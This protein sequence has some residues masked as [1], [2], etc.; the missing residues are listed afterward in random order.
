[1]DK[2]FKMLED[3]YEKYND[4][5]F[6][7]PD[8]LEYVLKCNDKKEQEVIGIIASSFA[9]GRVWAIL[10]IVGD[11]L[12]KMNSTP[13]EY[14][15]NSSLEDIKHEF[16]NLE[17]R[18]TTGTEIVNFL[19]GIKNILKE[20]GSLKEC[21]VSCENKNEKNIF[22]SAL[23]FSKKLRES[24]GI[25]GKDRMSLLPEPE[26]TSPC[27]RLI[28]YFRWMIRKDNVDPG[29]WEE[30]DKSKLLVPLDTHMLSIG[31]L[32]GFTKNKTASVKTAEAITS[33]F[34]MYNPQDP[35][36]YD[37]ALTR[38]GIRGDNFISDF[39]KEW[40]EN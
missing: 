19:S 8:P 2:R 13:R 18:F 10:K 39:E 21:F 37:F 24:S 9:Y 14:L 17:Y 6:V 5:S 7:H 30:L 1:M 27:K 4:S 40:N 16:E 3:L 31:K 20:Y 29:C 12:N 38:S 36:K 26:S 11:I 22:N 33:G 23:R 15:V 32:L 34:A 28:L 35:A 25:F